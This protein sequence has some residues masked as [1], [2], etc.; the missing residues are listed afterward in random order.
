MLGQGPIYTK[1]GWRYNMGHSHVFTLVSEHGYEL[2]K[3][4]SKE[5]KSL[6]GT[7][8]EHVK[9]KAHACFDPLLAH[10]KAYI[11]LFLVGERNKAS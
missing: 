2:N 5:K 3:G 6:S 10:M 11:F 7:P 4:K 9:K 1:V 8:W